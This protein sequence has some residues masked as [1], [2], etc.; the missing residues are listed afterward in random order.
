MYSYIM[1]RK[2]KDK[3]TCYICLSII[4]TLA[5]GYVFLHAVDAW[6]SD[7]FILI[8]A[9][10]SIPCLLSGDSDCVE[11][12]KKIVYCW[13]G[14][15][16][17]ALASVLY[18]PSSL[19][20]AGELL[21][22]FSL[23]GGITIVALAFWVQRRVLKDFTRWLVPILCLSLCVLM[24]LSSYRLFDKDIF[25]LILPWEVQAGTWQ[26]KVFSFYLVFLMWGA[27]ATLWRK[28]VAETFIA[29][30]LVVVSLWALMSYDSES[31][32]LAFGVGMLVF[33]LAHLP[34]K[35]YRYVIL[36][37]TCSLFLFVPLLWMFFAPLLEDPMAI[38]RDSTSFWSQYSAVR[39]RVFLYD[40]CAATVREAFLL[41]HGFGSFPHIHLP[42]GIVPPHHGR[43]PGG[44]P[45]N[46]VFLF[47][48]EYGIIGFLW[49]AGMFFVLFDYLYHATV[50]RVEGPAT[51]ALLISGQ[52]IFSL[53]F[54]IWIPDVVL[55]Y[56]MFFVILVIA[57]SFSGY[58]QNSILRE[59]VFN[60]AQYMVVLSFV[61]HFMNEY[62][63]SVS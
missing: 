50:D 45:H 44:H 15:L 48:L 26:N 1:R 23:L 22:T 49:L 37:F 58:N 32:Q 54:A 17:F 14:Y 56:G 30:G 27:V 12:N 34:L 57:T 62:F 35:K 11:I 28:S 40:F 13:F 63:L 8:L 18:P 9:F 47:L 38:Y 52:V 20:D 36:L 55:I 53:S 31:S 4:L 19:A 6:Y 2:E 5:T 43:F 7:I 29:A 3:W 24:L 42:E 10:V 25:E 51:F 33:V 16:G 61:C 46:I 39:V 41:G 21:K 60:G 59:R